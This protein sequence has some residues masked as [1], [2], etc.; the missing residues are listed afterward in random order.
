MKRWLTSVLSLFIVSFSGLLLADE[1]MLSGQE[2]EYLAKKDKL[3]V[4]VLA[5]RQS[6]DTPGEYVGQYFSTSNDYLS[7]LAAILNLPITLKKYP[8]IDAVFDAV[9]RGEVDIAMGYSMTEERRKKVL[10][11]APFYQTSTAVYLADPHNTTRPAERRRWVCLSGSVYCDVIQQQTNQRPIM[12]DSFDMGVAIV[13]SGKAHALVASYI[14]IANY[15]DSNNDLHASIEF[16]KWLPREEVRLV[17][18][19]EQSVLVGIINKVI[20]LANDNR[21]PSYFSSS[22][23]Y[24]L[25]DKALIA[26]HSLHEDEVVTYSM[27]DNLPPLISQS[28][29]G[30]YIGAI[31]DFIS[32][33][34]SRVG[35]DIQYLPLG[36]ESSAD[37]GVVSYVG[38]NPV[39]HNLVTQPFMTLKYR[40]V[41]G[42]TGMVKSDSKAGILIQTKISHVEQLQTETTL[43][44]VSYDD[45]EVMLKD[46]E[47]G[48]LSV[49]Y[50]PVD[51]ASTFTV[52]NLI[53]E[54]YKLIDAEL[55]LNLAFTVKHQD[56]ALFALINQLIS[57]FDNGE[58]LK[59]KN[60]YRQFE[61]VE[62]YKKQTVWYY[63]LL[64]LI[65]VFAL[66]GVLYL[67]LLNSKLKVEHR[68]RQVQQKDAELKRLQEIINEFNSVIFIAKPD[69][70]IQ[71]SNCPSFQKGQCQKCQLHD[72][73]RETDVLLLG[74]LEHLPQGQ[75]RMRSCQLN[76]HD[77]Q[78]A[79]KSIEDPASGSSLLLTIISDITEQKRYENSIL[80]ANYQERQAVKVRERFLA[81]MSHELRTPIAGLQGALEL[82]RTEVLSQKVATLQSQAYESASHLSRLVDTVLDFSKL[83][84][85][86]LSLVYEPAPPL[87]LVSEVVRQ[88]EPMAAK[89]ALNLEFTPQIS[90]IEKIHC[91]GVRI[92][93]VLANLLSNA[94]KFTESGVV[95]VQY[96]V[97]EEHLRLTI[98]DSGIGMTPEQIELAIQPF[99]QAEDAITT[100]KFGGTGLGLS[101][102]YQLVELMQ[103]HIECQ[104]ELG[105]GT[106][107]ELSIPFEKAKSYSDKSHVEVKL[108]PKSRPELESWLS[109]WGMQTSSV[110]VHDNDE[111]LFLLHRGN[112]FVL[113]LTESSYLDQIYSRIE[114]IDEVMGSDGVLPSDKFAAR[115][116][117]VD[118]NSINLSV[119]RLQLEYLGATVH[120]FSDAANAIEFIS[121]ESVD[122]VFT[123]YHMPDMDGAD[124]ATAIHSNP[125]KQHIPIIVCT[126]INDT[127]KVLEESRSVFSGVLNKPYTLEELH[128]QIFHHLESKTELPDWILGFPERERAQLATIF[129]DSMQRDIA[130][131][132]KAETVSAIK[133]V[134][135]KIKG[136]SAILGVKSVESLAL[137]IEQCELD[138][139]QWTLDD[140]IEEMNL[141]VAHVNNYLAMQKVEL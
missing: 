48:K 128:L 92:K 140:L 38:R 121:E 10:F 53:G 4:A 28:S 30:N 133:K 105:K 102:V 13:H 57:T 115:V 33:L 35:I 141:Q 27:R 80:E 85:N 34:G 51:V 88:F 1:L 64:V 101:I 47:Q 70:D 42:N 29:S 83:E 87:A 59:I 14:N 72:D 86:E 96:Q 97:E 93:Q 126:A 100:R 81:M 2:R 41:V 24:Y 43:N 79:S 119:M 112:D 91:D 132:G 58:I 68:E 90:A 69:G 66:L 21:L 32:M 15:V 107:F 9:S 78:V 23:P 136:G 122:I 3:R 36:S 110:K 61:M 5:T 8:N 11:S 124:L 108:I 104:S 125:L 37:L 113:N 89:K 123:D 99:K 19:Y 98:S 44:L 84:A 67:T 55:E 116:V 46:L 111:Q 22:N 103:G 137:Q 134:V 118:D 109:S 31:P 117:I 50:L 54:H 131:L 130:A 12:A 71:L 63:S 127:K 82:M 56:T 62:G 77:V 17:A 45:I 65:L 20:Q 94:I 75:Y 18:S 74:Q 6:Q 7:S 129:V 135:H 16:P 39:T 60:R 120:A 73:Q 76:F 25:L 106:C 26:F 40:G 139:V 52:S 95:S 49:I 114:H 138:E